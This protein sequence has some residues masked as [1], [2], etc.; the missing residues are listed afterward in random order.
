MDNQPM[1]GDE[2][3]PRS[4]KKREAI[5]SGALSLFLDKGFVG[6]SVDEIALHSGVSK[7]TVYKHFGD[8][9][10]LF[11][12]VVIDTIGRFGEPFFREVEDS[13]ETSD[14]DKTLISLGHTLLQTVLMPDVIQLRRLI[15]SEVARFPDL[16]RHYIE[17]GPGKGIDSLETLFDKYMDQGLL[18]KQDSRKTAIQFTWLVISVP[19]NH[20]MLMGDSAKPSKQELNTIVDEAVRIFKAAFL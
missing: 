5:M 17:Q 12:S 1:S 8:K 18:P 6:A 14:L 11:S 4:K 10:S 16:G 9:E 7:Q 13:R 19:I 20:V 15:V 2:L 3:T